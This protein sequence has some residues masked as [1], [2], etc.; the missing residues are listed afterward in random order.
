MHLKLLFIKIIQINSKE[1]LAEQF[2]HLQNNEDF[3]KKDFDFPMYILYA[4]EVENDE[5]YYPQMSK[6]KVNDE[7]TLD[8]VKVLG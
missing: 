5:K 2:K 1:E 8:L 7:E 3:E 6:I 4:K